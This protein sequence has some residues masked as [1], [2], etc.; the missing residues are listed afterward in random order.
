MAPGSSLEMDLSGLLIVSQLY[1]AEFNRIPTPEEAQKF[2]T[3]LK[4][5]IRA[6]GLYVP[7]LIHVPGGAL[8]RT[9]WQI[10]CYVTYPLFTHEDSPATPSRNERGHP[11]GILR[12]WPRVYRHICRKSLQALRST[13]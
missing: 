1:I 10:I 12:A 2:C 11:E 8:K 7:L 5:M 13:V 3:P 6:E 9:Q 4:D